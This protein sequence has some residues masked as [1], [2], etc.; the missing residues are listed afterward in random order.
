MND[1][2]YEKRLREAAD[3]SNRKKEERKKNYVPK[4]DYQPMAVP[5][6]DLM[7]KYRL[8]VKII[9]SGQG[10]SDQGLKG[11]AIICAIWNNTDRKIKAYIGN[12]Y[13]I[14]ENNEQ[15]NKEYD[16]EGYVVNNNFSLYPGAHIIKGDV[17][18]EQ[19]CG[20]ISPGWIY[21]LEVK[22]YTNKMEYDVQ[23]HLGNDWQWRYKCVNVSNC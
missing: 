4:D 14:N 22:D 1:E 7:D 16:Y 13:I 5:D 21:G 6:P 17:F 11:S 23:F 9:R 10:R 3:R 15:H 20:K 19:Y 2:E 12:S 18:M 8:K